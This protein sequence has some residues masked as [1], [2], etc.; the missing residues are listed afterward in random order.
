MELVDL[1][2]VFGRNNHQTLIQ[3]LLVFCPPEIVSVK[4]QLGEMFEKGYEEVTT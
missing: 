1:L 3:D 4:S 2:N